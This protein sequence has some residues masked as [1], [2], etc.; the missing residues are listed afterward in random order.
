LR[1]QFNHTFMKFRSWVS[2]YTWFANLFG[3]VFGVVVI[4]YFTSLI[5]DRLK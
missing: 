1:S 2:R 3:K 5:Q 4:C